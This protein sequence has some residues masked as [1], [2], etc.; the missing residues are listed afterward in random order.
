MHLLTGIFEFAVRIVEAAA[1]SGSLRS[2][3][4][5]IPSLIVGVI[6]Y[7]CLR[8]SSKM[9]SSLVALTVVGFMA[10]AALVMLALK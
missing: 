1:A 2:G 10:A 5:I 6:A 4:V 8:N 3:E 7:A 9:S